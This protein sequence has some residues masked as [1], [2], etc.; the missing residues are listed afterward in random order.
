[1]TV[2]NALHRLGIPLRP[3]GVH[4]FARMNIRLDRGIPADIRAGVEGSLS[5]WLRLQR[6]QVAMSFPTLRSAA[7]H[8]RI[9]Q[10]TLVVQF[11]RLEKDIGTTLYH[12][13]TPAAPQRPTRRGRKLLRDLQQDAV[14]ALITTIAPKEQN[15][16]IPESSAVTEAVRSFPRQRGPL[17]PYSDFAVTRLRITTAMLDLLADLMVHPQEQCY[18]AA[19]LV[20][21][22]LDPGNLYAQLKR[23]EAAGWL[24]SSPENEQ[25]WIARAPAGIG[26][27]RRRTQYSFTS[28]G[29]RAAEHEIAQRAAW[30]T[31]KAKNR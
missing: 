31:K 25:S 20:R 10:N 2:N 7:A 15:V 27:G 12:R 22:R 26:P 1:M 13:A 5:G 3:Q 18:G 16:P 17:T 4:S 24:I 14:K 19:I 6:F 9:Y 30:P 29:R 11:Q 21:I 28:E 8:L 23:L